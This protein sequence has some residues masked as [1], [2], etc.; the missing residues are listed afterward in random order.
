VHLSGHSLSLTSTKPI[1][2]VGI[3]AGLDRHPSPDREGLATLAIM[4]LTQ[5]VRRRRMCRS[6][7]ERPVEPAVVDRLLDLARRAPS[8][9]HTQG[10]SW[11][12]LEGTELTRRF[13]LLEAD[14]AWL[15]APS[16]PG[17]LRA[18]VILVPWSRPAA[19]QERYAEADKSGVGRPGGRRTEPGPGD[20]PASW[21]DGPGGGWLVPWWDVDLAF[22]VMLVL[23]AA[24][25]EGLGALFFALHGDPGRLA[26]GFGVPEDW[27]PLGAVALGWPDP[28]DAPSSSAR[29][30]RRPVSEVVHRG[31]W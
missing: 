7:L 3:P 31:R 4:E 15:A 30:G 5:A 12:V 21:G 6:F 9:G 8:A 18:P 26:A 20:Q 1:R 19:Y 29:R 28:G 13:W 25:D 22:S 27:R 23:L 16:H 17:L 24:V 10:W 2:G 14:P 11:L